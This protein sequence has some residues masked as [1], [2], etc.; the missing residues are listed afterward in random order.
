MER[1]FYLLIVV[2]APF[3]VIGCIFV[4]RLVKIRQ[5]WLLLLVLVPYFLSTTGASYQI[6]GQRS[7]VILNSEGR[8]YITIVVAEQESL[9]AKWVIQ[10][11]RGG[12]VVNVGEAL[13]LRVLKSQ[14]VMSTDYIRVA[15]N[16]YKLGRPVYGYIYL[17]N[18][19]LN[20]QNVLTEYP[21]I[22]AG[23][24]KIYSTDISEVYR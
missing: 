4:A 22:F 5:Q 15:T 3:L 8:D 19:D 13:G 17:R 6:F 7:S 2:L 23:K 21:E 1:T 16:E 11:R 24:N 9:A 10:Q 12:E 14:G 20:F 18:I